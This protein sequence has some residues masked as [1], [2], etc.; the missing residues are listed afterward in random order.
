MLQLK[1]ALQLRTL[2]Q[3]FR[4]ALDTAANLRVDAVELDLRNDLKID[5]LSRTAIRQILKHLDDRRLKVASVRFATRRGYDEQEE[6]E[7][8]VEATKLAMQKAFEL[9]ASIVCNPIHSVPEPSSEQG[10]LMTQVLY[11][12]GRHA[13]QVGASL[14]LSTAV[15]AEE[16]KILLGEN[17]P[18]IVLELDGAG[19]L[20]AGGKP[21][22][23]ASAFGDH[24]V[25][26]RVRDAV[27]DSSRKGGVEVQVGRGS[28]DFPEI[29]GKLEERQFTGYLL[30]GRDE[31]EDQIAERRAAEMAEGVEYLRNLWR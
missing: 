8:R 1:V 4:N 24:V 28:V 9:G 20:M 25:Q 26:L 6:L 5:E 2:H 12:L 3:P 7:R 10:L 17:R 11:D 29:L 21:E 22:E 15:T 16:L 31:P 14:A 30:L 19:V 18:G 13:V 27:R 23:V